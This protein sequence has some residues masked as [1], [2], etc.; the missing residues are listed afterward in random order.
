MLTQI[1]D[2]C[3]GS[4]V[5]YRIHGDKAGE[6]TGP[7]AKAQFAKQGIRVTSTPGYEPGNNGRAEKGVGLIKVHARAMLLT[8]PDERDRQELWPFAVQHAAYCSR[9]ASQ[10][11]RVRCPAFG[12][13]VSSRIKNIQ[14]MQPGADLFQARA[15][16]S[17][18]LGVDPDS[19][20]LVGRV[21][22]HAKTPKQRWVIESS[23]SF[24]VHPPRQ[25]PEPVREQP[26]EHISRGGI[27]PELRRCGD[28]AAHYGPNTEEGLLGAEGGHL[29]TTPRGHEAVPLYPFDGATWDI[30]ASTW[31]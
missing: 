20:W 19:Q 5:V 27:P 29:D 30:C 2:E 6:L 14:G 4:N 15:Q 21:N 17:L 13:M 23:S 26:P 22:R 31:T 3:E 18:F 9:M 16:D 12:E 25:L 28:R 24:V 11:K 1:R 7:K 10:G 8:I